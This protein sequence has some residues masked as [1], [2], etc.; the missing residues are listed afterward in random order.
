[1]GVQTDVVIADQSESQDIAISD[2][3][4]AT[5]DGF[6]FSGFQN[7]HLCTLLSLLKAG[8]PSAEFDHYLKVVE[9]ITS[10]SQESPVVFAVRPAEVSELAST[11]SLEE[12]EFESLAQSWGATEE[13]DGWASDDVRELL[14]E[15][16]DLA[17]S[18]SLEGKC[19]FL[20]QS[21]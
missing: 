21:L 8:S 10:R 1:M 6:T 18:A 13:F 7:V 11:A 16:G 15:L 14:R 5:W 17:E 9:L 19:I 20:W 4:A 3:P 2:S 12:E